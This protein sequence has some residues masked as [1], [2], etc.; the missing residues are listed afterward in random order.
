MGREFKPAETDMA[1]TAGLVAIAMLTVPAFDADV[2]MRDIDSSPSP[3]PISV[4][5]AYAFPSIARRFEATRPFVPDAIPED[6]SVM[7]L[8]TCLPNCRVHD[9]PTR[10]CKDQHERVEPACPMAEIKRPPVLPHTLIRIPNAA[11]RRSSIY[12]DL[13]ISS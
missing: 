13:Q 9:T 1:Y 12:V 8:P 2:W 11:E 4:I 6:N 7:C 3:F 10:V 5:F